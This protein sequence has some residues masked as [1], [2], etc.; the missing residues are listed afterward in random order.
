MKLTGNYPTC[1]CKRMAVLIKGFT[2]TAVVS[3]EAIIWFK[4]KSTVKKKMSGMQRWAKSD[5]MEVCGLMVLRLLA[6]EMKT[7][8]N[9]Y[10]AL[11]TFGRL[12]EAAVKVFDHFSVLPNKF[13]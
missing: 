6:C 10:T 3:G 7:I 12:F 8:K 1:K 5:Q 11:C 4:A 2:L 9:L 13:M